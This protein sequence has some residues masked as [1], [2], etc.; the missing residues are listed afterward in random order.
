MK[1]DR[2]DPNVKIKLNRETLLK[3]EQDAL[4]GARGGTDEIAIVATS[5]NSR[6]EPCCACA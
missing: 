5:N 3:L 4:S 6:R 2:K 1:K